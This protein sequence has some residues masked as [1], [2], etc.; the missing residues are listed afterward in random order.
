M[1][2]KIQQLTNRNQVRFQFHT[3]EQ[4]YITYTLEKWLPS[5]E[6]ATEETI[7]R[8]ENTALRETE[9]NADLP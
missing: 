6:D 5:P 2:K 8:E 7:I 9:I 4:L 1:K 3:G